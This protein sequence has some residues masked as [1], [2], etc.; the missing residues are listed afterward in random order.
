[1]ALD[2]PLSRTENHLAYLPVCISS[3]DKELGM[4]MEMEG[5]SQ[6]SIAMSLHSFMF[7]GLV[8]ILMVNLAWCYYLKQFV[9]FQ[10]ILWEG[11]FSLLISGRSDSS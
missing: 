1:V 3:K 9:L 8:L 11:K 4:G 2:L 6:T 7:Q 10:D 5:E